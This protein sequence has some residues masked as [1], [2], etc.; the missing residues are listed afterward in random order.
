MKWV[1][2]TCDILPVFSRNSGFSE[3]KKASKIFIVEIGKNMYDMLN[4]AGVIK[5]KD[6][7]IVAFSSDLGGVKTKI[8]LSTPVMV[9]A[10][11][12]GYG[13]GYSQVTVF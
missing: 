4:R 12:D 11:R 2:Q 1:T 8:F 3:Q 9:G 7:I 10:P 5:K 6:L 13:Y